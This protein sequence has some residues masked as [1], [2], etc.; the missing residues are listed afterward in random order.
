MAETSPPSSVCVSAFSMPEWSNVD[1]P[2]S[3]RDAPGVLSAV[4][5]DAVEFR[6]EEVTVQSLL[7][8]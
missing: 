2:E 4:V 5:P 6:S 8:P 3:R 1:V 7:H